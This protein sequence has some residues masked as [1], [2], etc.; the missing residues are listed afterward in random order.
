LKFSS[1][2]FSDA[3]EALCFNSGSISKTDWAVR[4]V[5]H[6]LSKLSLCPSYKIDI[7]SK[8]KSGLVCTCS[9]AEPLGGVYG[10]TSIGKLC[11]SYY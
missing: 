5:H 2:F 11:F 3:E 6:L 8:G 1:G 9:C 10:D 4:L 7:T